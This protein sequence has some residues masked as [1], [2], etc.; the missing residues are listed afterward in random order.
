MLKEN[1]LSISSVIFCPV[2]SSILLFLSI[3][4]ALDA[5]TQL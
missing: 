5:L 3:A 1:I 2:L 4:G